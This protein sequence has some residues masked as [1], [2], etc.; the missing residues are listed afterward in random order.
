MQASKDKSAEVSPFAQVVGLGA[1]DTVL[2]R[3]SSFGC[4]IGLALLLAFMA[5]MFGG[6]AFNPTLKG[7]IFLGLLALASLVGAFLLVRSALRGRSYQGAAFYKEGLAWIDNNGLHTLR[8]DQVEEIYFSITVRYVNGIKGATIYTT[9]F[10]FSEKGRLHMDNS[11]KDFSKWM[12][13][14]QDR[15]M[16]ALL[17][18]FL[19]QFENGQRIGFGNFSLDKDHLYYNTIG[20]SWDQVVNIEFQKGNVVVNTGGLFPWAKVKIAKVPNL[21]VFLHFE[22]LCRDLVKNAKVE[23]TAL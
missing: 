7:G 3:G 1:Q 18:R 19:Q 23:A 22:K 12:D 20:I 13:Y 16:T 11:Y 21:N 10:H 14:L 6:T 8:W 2:K 15:V 5:F 4:M 9:D 17:P